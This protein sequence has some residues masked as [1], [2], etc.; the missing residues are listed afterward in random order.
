MCTGL[1]DKRRAFVK[2]AFWAFWSVRESHPS[3]IKKNAH[4]EKLVSGRVFVSIRD[5][6]LLS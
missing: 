2:D 6:V 5:E 3:K 4:I 1:G